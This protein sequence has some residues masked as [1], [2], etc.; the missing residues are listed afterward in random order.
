[1][2]F[3][4]TVNVHKFVDGQY[5]IQNIPEVTGMSVIFDVKRIA[6]GSKQYDTLGFAVMPLFS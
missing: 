6:S 3:T 2:D 4:S 5:M 1:M